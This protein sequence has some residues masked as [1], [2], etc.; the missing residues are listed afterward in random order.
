MS[1]ADLSHPTREQT[2]HPPELIPCQPGHYHVR[3]LKTPGLVGTSLKLLVPQQ[4]RYDT[5]TAVV[6]SL[7]E[8][9]PYH[10]SVGDYVILA[11][12][13]G[14]Y[15]FD[16]KKFTD[17]DIEHFAMAHPHLNYRQCLDAMGQED[18]PMD[19]R[20]LVHPGTLMFVDFRG[21]NHFMVSKDDILIRI[22]KEI[23][24]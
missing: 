13:E 3:I 9:N 17:E 18:T 24:Q 15:G 11:M 22:E 4:V 20:Y 19:S 12:K 2:P 16:K 10:L 8:D 6:V 5:P 1:N 23:P 14:G 21:H 7:P